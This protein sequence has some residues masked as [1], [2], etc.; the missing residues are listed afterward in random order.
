MEKI[1]EF[2]NL[3]G[4]EFLEF[5]KINNSRLEKK[6]HPNNESYSIFINENEFIFQNNNIH[7]I[8][9]REDLDFSSNLENLIN[10][11]ESKN[12]E[13]EVYQK[14]SYGK[15]IVIKIKEHIFFEYSYDTNKFILD[16]IRISN[17]E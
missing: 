4:C 3:L 14:Y 1:F 16:L 5:E 8:E 10:T 9:I 2:L 12:I 6:F 7:S 11:F 15:N 17:N 13:W